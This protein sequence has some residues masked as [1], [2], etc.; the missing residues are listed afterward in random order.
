MIRQ[1]KNNVTM[2]RL[3]IVIFL[4]IFHEIS[5]TPRI[6]S[7]YYKDSVDDILSYYNDIKYNE[8]LDMFINHLGYKE[9]GN[10]W[11]IVNDINCLGEWQ[12]SESTL[13]HLGY[14]HITAETFKSDSSIFPRKLQLEI[15]KTYMKI[16]ELSLKPYEKYIGTEINGI[17][18]T[19]SG[20]LAGSHLGGVGS[21]KLFIESNGFIDKEDLYGTKISNYIKEFSIYDL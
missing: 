17:P 9:S 21:I 7:N 4:L 18:I 12:F 13:K 14:E 2:K 8:Q 1:L 15:L 10:N 5:S 11:K 19:K 3:I 20:L 6:S 16:N